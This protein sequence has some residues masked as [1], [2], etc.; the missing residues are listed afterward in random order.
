MKKPK[1][2]MTAHEIFHERFRPGAEPRSLAYRQG[3]LDRLRYDAGEGVAPKYLMCYEPGTAER[4][5]WLAGLA[6]GR[7]L[8]LRSQDDGAEQHT[9]PSIL[10]PQAS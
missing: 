10:K 3:V 6:A 1:S 9:L 7:L 8:W 5:A 2:N 4:D